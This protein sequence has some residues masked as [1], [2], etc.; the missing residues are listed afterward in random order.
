MAADPLFHFFAITQTS[1]KDQKVVRIRTTQSLQTDLTKL[2]EQQAEDFIDRDAEE[3]AFD[4]GYKVDD[5]EIFVI[6]NFPLGNGLSAASKHPNQFA[7]HPFKMR[8]V[9]RKMQHS[10]THDVVKKVVGK[11]QVFDGRNSK[12]LRRHKS[13]VLPERLYCFRVAVYSIHLKSL[14]HK[15]MQVATTSRP[16]IEDALERHIPAFHD[17]VDEVYVGVAQQRSYI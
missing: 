3:I 9:F 5:H 10:A 16:G 1:G 7:E 6:E 8:L 12:T 4:G 13:K 2:F 11:R 15:P 17:L 14:P